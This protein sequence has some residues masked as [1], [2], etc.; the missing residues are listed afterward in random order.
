MAVDRQNQSY[1]EL[2]HIS[3][4][5]NQF[6]L[7]NTRD[8]IAIHNLSDLSYEY[9]NPATLKA[10]GYEKEELLAK[11]AIG[12]VHPDDK[13][14][15]LIYLKEHL[16]NS[17]RHHEEFRYQ[18][19]DGVYIWLEVTIDVIPENSSIVTISRDINRLKQ[20]K[21]H[22]QSP[23]DLF[24]TLLE[25]A[26]VAIGID[27]DGRNLFV[28]G[29]FLDLFGYESNA[30]L[31]GASIL[32]QVAPSFRDEIA[33]HLSLRSEGRVSP[34]WQEIQGQ[35]KDGSIFPLLVQVYSIHLPNGPANIAFLTDLSGQ[36]QA[37]AA[38]KQHIAA[39]TLIL[40]I[41]DIFHKLSLEDIDAMINN[42]LKMIGEFD[43]NDRS[44]VFLLSEDGST[45]TNTHE[46]CRQGIQ[47]ASTEIQNIPVSLYPWGMEKLHTIKH[48]YIPRANDL[49]PEAHR[50][51]EIMKAHSVQ[52]VFIVPMILENQLIGF[53]GFDSVR[54][55]KIWSK[56]SIM[57]LESVAHIFANAIQRKKYNLYLNQAIQVL[58]TGLDRMQ[59]IMMQFVSSLGTVL[60]IRDPHTSGHQR[61][62]AKLA[63]AIAEEMKLSEDQ[64]KGIAV[65]GTLHDIGTIKVP[66]EIM[67]KPQGLSDIEFELI[68]THSQAGYE[69]VKE[70]DFPWPVAKAILQHHERMN[71]TGYPRKLAGDDIL[72]EAKIV[73]VAD[74][75]EAITSHRPHRKALGIDMALDE[76]SHNSGILYDTDVVEACM[77]LFREER[78]NWN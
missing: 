23:G 26:P 46:W 10:L 12:L 43:N 62:V 60:D 75:V 4:R 8:L 40:E 16:H 24:Y 34:Y 59:K 54:S 76:I 49:P 65:A 39:Q 70:I 18:K 20:D 35:R 3:A 15:F 33:E 44:Y 77:R 17:V 29:A 41:S 21:E 73:A 69:I 32:N 71:G 36:K 2:Q 52:S 48:I 13:E 53:L 14:R 27:R 11:N 57:I 6:I 9:V 50:E 66:T 72:L 28:N 19:K 67:S 1:N 22:Q 45:I 74:V 30:E 5:F 56:E 37:E 61:K 63:E 51:K 25:Q 7:D 64:I 31:L 78:F 38:M 68:K 58:E 42:T 55:E 47:A